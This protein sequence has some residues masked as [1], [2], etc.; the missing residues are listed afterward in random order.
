MEK[1]GDFLSRLEQEQKELDSRFRGL[2]RFIHDSEGKFNI[3]SEEHKALLVAQHGIM[4]AYLHILDT[5]ITLL[6]K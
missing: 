1:E 6:Q 3:L 5:R 4:S 2:D